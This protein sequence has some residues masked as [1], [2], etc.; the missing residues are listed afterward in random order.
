MFLSLRHY[1]TG[2]NFPCE[3]TPLLSAVMMQV[4]VVLLSMGFWLINVL[5]PCFH[6]CWMRHA[7]ALGKLHAMV[8]FSCWWSIGIWE[9]V[10]LRPTNMNVAVANLRLANQ[11]GLGVVLVG[12]CSSPGGAVLF[13]LVLAAWFKALP[14][15][16]TLKSNH[17]IAYNAAGS[18]VYATVLYWLIKLSYCLFVW[19][20]TR[21]AIRRKTAMA[22]LARAD[23]F[24]NSG[25]SA[26]SKL[27]EHEHSY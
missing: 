19:T 26:G 16:T 13:S 24:E 12:T 17:V 2:G 5:F 6:R 10:C 15:H 8:L 23:Y 20:R 21:S 9:P 11:I 14:I 1:S 18:L 4:P 27:P 7:N 22:G 25:G 3:A